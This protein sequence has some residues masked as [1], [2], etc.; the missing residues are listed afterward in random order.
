MIP[1]CTVLIS[2]VEINDH[3]GVGVYL[4]RL[5]QRD[6]NVIALRSKSLYG[7]RC[8]FSPR[9]FEIGRSNAVGLGKWRSKMAALS[10]EM[11]AK[12]IIAVPYY[13]QDFENAFS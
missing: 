11:E 12:R 5:F 13:P 8:V 9:S 1:G 4:A 2:A 3:H 6:A 7:G 10:S